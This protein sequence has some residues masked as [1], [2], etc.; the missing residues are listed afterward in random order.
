MG[1]TAALRA[2]LLSAFGVTGL[3]EVLL[4]ELLRF[5]WQDEDYDSGRVCTRMVVRLSKVF[6][7]SQE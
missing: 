1:R 6:S 2:A 5:I 3:D 4:V 7:F